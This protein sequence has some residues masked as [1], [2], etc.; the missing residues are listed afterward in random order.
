MRGNSSPVSL[1]ESYYTLLNIEININ[2]YAYIDNYYKEKNNEFLGLQKGKLEVIKNNTIV[3]ATNT[4]NNIKLEYD[5]IT[6]GYAIRYIKFFTLAGK[7]KVNAAS[8]ATPL[9]CHSYDNL[10]VLDN[11]Y[12]FRNSQLHLIIDSTINM[13]PNIRVTIDNT[14]QQPNIICISIQLIV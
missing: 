13:D 7:F 4:G 2:E 11:V 6:N 10:N 1:E 3:L 12:S 8:D 5:S 14:F 9:F